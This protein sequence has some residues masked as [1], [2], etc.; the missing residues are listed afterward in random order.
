MEASQ[1][2]KAETHTHLWMIFRDNMKLEHYI[3]QV[4]GQK[5]RFLDQI[6]NDK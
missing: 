6:L 2:T 1:E 3:E 4:R 5:S